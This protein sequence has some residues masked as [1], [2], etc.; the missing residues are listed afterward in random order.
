[1]SDALEPANPFMIQKVGAMYQVVPEEQ[2]R[3]QQYLTQ[4]QNPE[5]GQ[6]DQLYQ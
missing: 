5:A 6:S 1:M 2:N 4:Y 3:I